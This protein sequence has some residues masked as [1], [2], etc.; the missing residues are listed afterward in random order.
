MRMCL[1]FN[2]N[3]QYLKKGNKKYHLSKIPDREESKSS[4]DYKKEYLPLDYAFIESM[5][6]LF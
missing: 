4:K 1:L 2:M 3:L 6:F 5:L